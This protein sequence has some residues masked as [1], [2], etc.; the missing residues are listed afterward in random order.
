[1]PQTEILQK[2]KEHAEWA[3]AN[4]WETPITLGDDITEAIRTIRVLG[5]ELATMRAACDVYREE[6][7]RMKEEPTKKKIKTNGDYIRSL[8][9]AKL[10]KLIQTFTEAFLHCSLART[11]CDDCPMCIFCSLPP[12]EIENWV[13]GTY[14]D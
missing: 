5:A 3:Q 12:S 14:H 4:E 11:D 1:M 6:I 8:S 7:A 9:N 2:L 10:I 13:K